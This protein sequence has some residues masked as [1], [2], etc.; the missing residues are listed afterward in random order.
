MGF[1][2]IQVEFREYKNLRGMLN[3]QQHLY[4]E[5][6]ISSSGSSMKVTCP[7]CGYEWNTNSNLI[8]VTCPSCLRKIR[9]G[10]KK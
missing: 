9:K 8:Y 3:Q 1:E 4:A 7:N 5:K 2:D 6:T 10:G